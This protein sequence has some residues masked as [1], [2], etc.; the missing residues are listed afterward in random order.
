MGRLVAPLLLL[1]LGLTAPDQ[2]AAQ[3]APPP[4]VTAKECKQLRHHA[5]TPEEFHKCA[6]WCRMQA[7]GY[8]K[9]EAEYEAEL[10]AELH[11]SPGHFGPKWQPSPE[12]LRQEV[13]Y[14][15]RLTQH[16]SRMAESYDKRAGTAAPKAG[17]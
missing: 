9:Q 3:T 16:W 15:H 13:D 12:H 8:H 10:Q 4:T 2:S 6:V 17:M 11:S 14:Y 5:A 1:V 7:V